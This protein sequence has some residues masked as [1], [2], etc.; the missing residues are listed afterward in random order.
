MEVARIPELD[1]V[2]EEVPEP[3]ALGAV[4]LPPGPDGPGQLAGRAPLVLLQRLEETVGHR[5]PPGEEPLP[6]LADGLRE[7]PLEI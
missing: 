6:E 4:L 2:A 7:E 1:L 3:L 5:P